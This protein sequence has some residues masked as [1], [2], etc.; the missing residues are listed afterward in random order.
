MARTILKILIALGLVAAGCSAGRAQVPTVATPD[1]LLAIDGPA[2]RINVECLRGCSLQ[3]GRDT[4]MPNSP[5]MTKFWFMCGPGTEKC[6][7]TVN[8][9][10]RK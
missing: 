8:G 1:F 5:Q 9:F 7:G 4:G 6:S 10:L 3:G 2:G